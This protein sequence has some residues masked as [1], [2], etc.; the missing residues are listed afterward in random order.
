RLRATLASLQERTE[1]LSQ[2]QQAS[3]LAT[4][5][6]NSETMTTAWDE[7]STEIFGR[8]FKE[9]NH[10]TSPLEHVVPKDRDHMCHTVAAAVASGAPIKF[11]FRVRW[12][13][14]D[15]R[16]L[17]TR[18]TRVHPTSRFWRGV[19]FDIT[20]RKVVE[21]ALV[22]SEKLAA[23][24]RL[25]STVA[26]EVNNPLEAVTNLLFLARTDPALNPPTHSYLTLAE[27]ELARLANI[28]RL[29]LSFVR[30]R[31]V[32]GPV[33][34]SQVLD[35]VLCLFRCKCE[36]MNVTV[37]RAYTPGVHIEIPEHELRQILINLISNAVDALVPGQPCIR[38]Q[39]I[40]LQDKI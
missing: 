28:T 21:A 4:W 7:G 29:T 31:G 8:S 37:E 13:N 20:H 3:E 33:E 17:E 30:T 10:L 36:V 22:R 26:H 19:T 18:G 34:V 25:A 27:Q 2:A 1:A 5:L 9:F 23:M 39:T 12:P 35:S 38:L 6:F 16:W 40:Q 32:S 11:E 24:G 15:I 14:G